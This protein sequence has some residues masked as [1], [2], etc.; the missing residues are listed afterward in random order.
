[1]GQN[2]RPTR[3]KRVRRHRRLTADSLGIDV[4]IGIRRPT[5]P[6]PGMARCVFLMVAELDRYAI[7]AQYMLRRYACHGDSR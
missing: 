2:I 5:Q 6:M 3:H 4:K 1:M 7:S